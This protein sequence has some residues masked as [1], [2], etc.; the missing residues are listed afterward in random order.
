MEQAVRNHV[1]CWR[2]GSRQRWRH[3]RGQQQQQHYEQ[4]RGRQVR[5]REGEKEVGGDRAAA[6]GCV[7][8]VW[9]SKGAQGHVVGMRVPR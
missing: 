2:H 8:S 7:W 4:H 1:L 9:G 6:S 5:T 3:Q